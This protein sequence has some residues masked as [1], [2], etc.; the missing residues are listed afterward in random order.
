M[1]NGHFRDDGPMA[2]SGGDQQIPVHPAEVSVFIWSLP[3][4]QIA[5]WS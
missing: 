3:S 4:R 1:A 5:A 2:G